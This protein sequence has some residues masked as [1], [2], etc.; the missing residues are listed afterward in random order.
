MENTKQYSTLT[1]EGLSNMWGM[2]LKN[3]IMMIATTT[4]QSIMTTVISANRFR[5]YNT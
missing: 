3:T 2:V 5:T 4:H 1:L